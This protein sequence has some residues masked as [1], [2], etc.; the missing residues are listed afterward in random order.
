VIW[1]N[2]IFVEEDFLVADAEVH[3]KVFRVHQVVIDEGRKAPDRWQLMYYDI[4]LSHTRYDD[5]APCATAKST[6]AST[7]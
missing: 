2:T 3:G 4:E 7:A 1:P 5:G 6:V